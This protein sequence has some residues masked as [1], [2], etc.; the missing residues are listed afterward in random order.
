[1][2][3]DTCCPVILGLPFYVAPKVNI[4]N[5]KETMYLQFV[6]EEVKF[7]FSQFKKLPYEKKTETKEERTIL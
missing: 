1:M 4:D 3:L 5:K 2:Y 6:E 7:E